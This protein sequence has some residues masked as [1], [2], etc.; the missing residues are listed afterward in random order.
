MLVFKLNIDLQFSLNA[1]KISEQ[2]VARRAQLNRTLQQVRALSGL[3]LSSV[4]NILNGHVEAR[5]G[6][7]EVLADTLDANWVLVPKHLL[8]EVQR[9][10]SGKVIGPDPAPSTV[11]QLFSAGKR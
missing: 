2:L 1:M 6:T 8:P 5:S 11:E 10:L 7:L 4:S 3:A 9:L